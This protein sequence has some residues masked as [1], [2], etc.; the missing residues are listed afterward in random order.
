MTAQQL[1]GAG[2]VTELL[3]HW[4]EEDSPSRTKLLELVYRQ[5]RSIAGAQ[6]LGERPDHTLSATALVH[7]AYLRLQNVRS[8]EWKNRSHFLAIAS[9]AMRRVLVDHARERLTEQRGK[10]RT[11]L[12][13]EEAYFLAHN[14]PAEYLRLAE[15]LEEL[16][17][18]DPLKASIVDLRYFG[19]LTLPETATNLG[20][21]RATVARHWKIAMGWLYRDLTARE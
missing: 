3:S 2:E 17:S 11:P 13:L 7:E 16:A 1:V 20:I 14:R 10:G 18:V 6:M 8:I 21:S 15:S 4:Y 19:G 12:P 9:Q 5:L